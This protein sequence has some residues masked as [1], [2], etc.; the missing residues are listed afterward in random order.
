[1]V[2]VAGRSKGCSTCR[3]RRVK[4]DE[5]R[6]ICVRCEKGGFKCDGPKEVRFIKG[7]IVKSRRSLHQT[8][9]S[10]PLNGNE[11]E[12]YICFMLKYTTR[13]DPIE[14]ATRKMASI[15]VSRAN[16]TVSTK[17]VS[18][19]AIMSF[20]M[21]FFGTEHRRN[22]ITK[23]G[24]AMYGVAL[25]QINH[26]L[27]DPICYKH[28]EL[29][30]SVLTLAVLET[31]VPTGMGINFKHMRAV[32]EL[33]RLQDISS[34][35]PAHLPALYLHVRHLAIFSALWVREPSIL[36]RPDWKRVLRSSCSDEEREQQELYDI[37]ADCTVLFAKRDKLLAKWRLHIEKPPDQH[38][39]LKQK[40]QNLLMQLCAWR[41]RWDSDERNSYSATP[42]EG[43]RP[44]DFMPFTTIF[45]FRDESI[46][47]MFMFYNI[48]LIYILQLLLTLDFK[49]PSFHLK[50]HHTLHDYLPSKA[51]RENTENRYIT[52][53]RLA[54]LDICRSIPYHL[55]QVSLAGYEPS[56]IAHWAL[57]TVWVKVRGDRSAE[58]KWLAAL[59]VAQNPVLARIVPALVS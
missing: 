17:G 31:L 18:H 15:G 14:V 4:C 22:S 51:T 56:P 54:V 40:V 9:P 42:M 27:S 21:I 58:G 35:I 39:A 49:N 7:T 3:Q 45:T 43:P 20:A 53:Q 1:M 41:Q 38:T 12:R 13:G 36:A 28:N 25:K 6:P 26:A 59:F 44:D 57:A 2:N 8:P 11:F 52:A 32:E 34:P 47:I 33:L 46:A 55:D 23:G 24:Y 48:T 16:A 5:H 19:Q 50:S 37:L 10:A 30:L 29:I